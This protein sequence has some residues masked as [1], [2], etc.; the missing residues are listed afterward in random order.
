MDKWGKRLVDQVKYYDAK[1]QI[2]FVSA[3]KV[4][5]EIMNNPNLDICDKADL[6][7]SFCKYWANLQLSLDKRYNMVK[8][9]LRCSI[10]R[11]TKKFYK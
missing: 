4:M 2:L 6:Y 3:D 10:E 7:D 1:L 11:E 8:A 5:E 9:F